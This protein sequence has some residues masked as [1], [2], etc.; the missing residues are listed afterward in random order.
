MN[1]IIRAKEFEQRFGYAPD[2]DDLVRVN[3]PK[4]GEIEHLSCGVC[5]KHNR[6]EYECGCRVINR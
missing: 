2:N 3:C 4:A 5:A 1:K 6:P